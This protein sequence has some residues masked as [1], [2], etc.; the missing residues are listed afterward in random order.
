[1]NT[2]DNHPYHQRDSKNRDPSNQAA[3]TYALERLA[4]GI[5]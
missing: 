2:R 3:K 4:T 1:M 5:V